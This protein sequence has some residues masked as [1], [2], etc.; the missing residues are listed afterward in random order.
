MQ[1]SAEHFVQTVQLGADAA[2]G[3]VAARSA[4]PAGTR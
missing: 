2:S 4:P 3:V 1:A